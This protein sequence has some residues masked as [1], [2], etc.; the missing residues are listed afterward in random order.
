MLNLWMV[1]YNFTFVS[2]L[3]LWFLLFFFT[4]HFLFHFFTSHH[5]IIFFLFLF[6]LLLYSFSH[7]YPSNQ[8]QSLTDPLPCSNSCF[9]SFSTWTS[10]FLIEASVFFYFEMDTCINYVRVSSIFDILSNWACDFCGLL[11]EEHAW[12]LLEGPG[13][14]VLVDRNIHYYYF[15]VSNHKADLNLS[16]LYSLGSFLGSSVEVWLDSTDNDHLL[17]VD[18]HQVLN[19]GHLMVT[20]IEVISQKLLNLLSLVWFLWSTL[21]ILLRKLTYLLG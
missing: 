10:K 5:F 6:Q 1:Y 2:G 11:F 20:T 9:V 14:E 21:V 8:P 17:L 16:H 7:H 18:N 15:L 13:K 3:F 19:S 4:Y 12:E